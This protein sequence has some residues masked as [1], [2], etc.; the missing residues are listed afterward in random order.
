MTGFFS[1]LTRIRGG[2]PGWC[3]WVFPLVPLVV[4]GT[5]Y[6][7]AAVER[8]EENPNDKLMPLPADFV[9]AVRVSLTRNEFTDEIPLVADLSSSLRI[10]GIGF[11]AAVLFSLVAGLHIGAWRWANAMFDPFL[12]FLSYLPP[13]ALLPLVLLFLGIGDTA[14]TF[15]IFIAVAVPLTR[16]L[17]LRVEG[18]GERQIWNALTLGP[19]PMEMIWIVIRRLTEPGFLDDVRLLI[20]TAWVYLIAAELIASNAGLGYRINVASRNLNVAQIFFYI[21]II[22]LLAFLMDRGIYH[23]NRLRNRWAFPQ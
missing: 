8:R 1:A 18:I 21:G 17:V 2:L 14:K 4:V 3:Q 10:F 19:S 6:F 13:L 11:G 7:N 12:R 22:V 15:L 20:G 16:S 9:K 23:L 5:L